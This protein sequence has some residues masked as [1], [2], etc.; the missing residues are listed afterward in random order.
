MQKLTAVLLLIVTPFVQGCAIG[1]LA[2][3]VGYGVGQGRKA[4]AQM[5]EAKAKYVEKY[6]NYRVELEKI[7][8]ER[9]K[10]GLKPTGIP[11]FEEWLETQPLSASEIKLFQKYGVLSAKELKTKGEEQKT[12]NVSESAPLKNEPKGNFS[13]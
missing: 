9:E 8:L 5:L 10:A 4:S 12:K 11:T 7:N 2:A 6:Q 13:K 1:V 3:G